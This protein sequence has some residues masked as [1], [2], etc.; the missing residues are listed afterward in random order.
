MHHHDIPPISALLVDNSAHMRRLLK[1]V[2]S[3][4]GVRRIVEAGDGAEALKEM[5]GFRPDIVL[6]EV[7]MSPLDGIELARLVRSASDS[8]NPFVPILIVSSYA[9]RENIAAARDA[10]VNEFIAKPVSA[11]IVAKHLHAT[12]TSPRRFVLNQSF[13][14]PDR[15]R[16]DAPIFGTRERRHRRDGCFHFR[17]SQKGPPSE[18]TYVREVDG[19]VTDDMGM[20]DI[21][22]LVHG[23]RRQFSAVG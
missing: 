19:D 13:F 14:G 15:R 5:R 6:S 2:L 8:P 3:S 11:E 10:G 9:V 7:V 22:R 1:T 20:M 23:V 12:L 18:W 4:I 17:P 16:R 21:R